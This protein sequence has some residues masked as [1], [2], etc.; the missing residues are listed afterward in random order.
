MIEHRNAE[1]CLKTLSGLWY[2]DL[3]AAHSTTDEMILKGWA[4]LEC[5]IKMVALRIGTGSVW[6]KWK[7]LS[8]V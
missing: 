7:T 6:I 4:N 1:F 2:P 5:P 3:V 8:R